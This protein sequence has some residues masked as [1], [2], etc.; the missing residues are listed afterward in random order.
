M[1]V[2]KGHFLL[3]I[4]APSEHAYVLSL[5]A[6]CLPPPI[7]NRLPALRAVASLSPP[8]GQDKIISSIFPHFLVFSLIFPQSFFIFFLVLIFRAS[9]L[10]TRKGPGY[11]T[12]SPAW[13]S[14]LF[15]SPCDF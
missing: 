7:Q 12:G 5:L 8:G 2:G 15:D 10:P 3:A 14:G 4:P 1:F 6:H 9:G 11:A 13:F